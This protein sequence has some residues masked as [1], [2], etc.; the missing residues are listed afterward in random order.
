MKLPCSAGWAAAALVAGSLAASPAEGHSRRIAHGPTSPTFVT[1]APPD[2]VS[3]RL[4]LRHRTAE[5]AAVEADPVTISAAATGQPFAAHLHGPP[6]LASGMSLRTELVLDAPTICVASTEPAARYRLRDLANALRHTFAPGEKLAL[7]LLEAGREP[8][9]LGPTDRPAEVLAWLTAS[10]AARP[11]TQRLPA[12]DRLGFKRL[13][14]ATEAAPSEL[15]VWLLLTAGTVPRLEA[16]DAPM[17][18]GVG[19]GLLENF[20][21]AEAAPALATERK[22]GG[23]QT[24]PVVEH[25]RKA[26]VRTTA[27]AGSGSGSFCDAL[28]KSGGSCLFGGLLTG[29][30]AMVTQRL[31]AEGQALF[32]T[33]MSC[34]PDD[35]GEV[36][37]ATEAGAVTVSRHAL[38]NARCDR[39]QNPSAATLGGA[40]AALAAALA[41][42]AAGVGWLLFR[43]RRAHGTSTA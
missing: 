9:R 14:D 31:L 1:V 26:G 32:V 6:L 38:S 35:A 39:W 5:G 8:V 37:I 30:N 36:R 13:R 24:D 20:L 28:A 33:P 43:R 29:A 11:A 40:K 21:P 10:C 17:L 22:P 3:P 7:T 4:V 27:A 2:G 19:V 18:A 15:V 41:A 23:Y 34:L 16:D 25:L 12:F 42:I